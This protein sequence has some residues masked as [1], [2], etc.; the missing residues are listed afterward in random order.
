MVF[1]TSVPSTSQGEKAEWLDEAHRLSSQAELAATRG[2]LK[3]SAELIV[4]ALHCEHR[5]DAFGPQILQ[6]I[7]PS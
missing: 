1:S 7:K 5:A 3:R 4:Q 2:D 6:L